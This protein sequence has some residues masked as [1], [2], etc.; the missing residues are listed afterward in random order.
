MMLC[1]N[2]IV[3]RKRGESESSHSIKLVIDVKTFFY[4]YMELAETKDCFSALNNIGN[5]LNKINKIY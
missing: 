5:S 2:H 1:Y 3:V 4:L